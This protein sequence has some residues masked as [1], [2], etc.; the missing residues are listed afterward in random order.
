MGRYTIYIRGT[1]PH[2]A[3]YVRKSQNVQAH[4]EKFSFPKAGEEIVT[5]SYMC[6]LIV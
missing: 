1:I 6:L 5:V 4:G 2:G 3:V